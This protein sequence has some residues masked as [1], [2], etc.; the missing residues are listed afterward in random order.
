MSKLESVRQ[1]PQFAA[2]VGIDW[3]D[4][5][6]AWCLQAADSQKRESGELEHTPEAESCARTIRYLRSCVARDGRRGWSISSRQISHT[7][8]RAAGA[9]TK[10]TSAQLAKEHG[11]PRPPL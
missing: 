4:Q 9:H 5:K 8:I 11:G 7:C 2:F 1:E 6:H 10:F 3:A